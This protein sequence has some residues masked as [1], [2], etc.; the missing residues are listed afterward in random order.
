M[1]TAAVAGALRPTRF[2]LA[3]IIQDQWITRASFMMC[4]GK[5]VHTQKCTLSLLKGLTPS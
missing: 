5:L 4:L 1:I 2:E 3:R